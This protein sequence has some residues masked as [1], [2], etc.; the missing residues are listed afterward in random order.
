MAHS[1]F[2]LHYVGIPHVS[3]KVGILA[4]PLFHSCLPEDSKC[5]VVQRQT[6][7]TDYYF[8]QQRPVHQLKQMKLI[9]TLLLWFIKKKTKTKHEQLQVQFFTI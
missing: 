2:D 1:T 5:C 3:L 4:L 9:I 7:L 8:V 6:T